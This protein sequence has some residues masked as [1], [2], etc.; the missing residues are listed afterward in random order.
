MVG[1][2]GMTIPWTCGAGRLLVYL[3][4][5]W[6]SPPLTLVNEMKL[7]PGL[8]CLVA[9]VWIRFISCCLAIPRVSW[10]FFL[11]TLD[12]R[13]LKYN[14]TEAGQGR[15]AV[16]RHFL[17]SHT[18]LLITMMPDK[19]IDS[20]AMKW[21]QMWDWGFICCSALMFPLVLHLEPWGTRSY[22]GTKYGRESLF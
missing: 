17:S 4:C 18:A 12:T 3:I 7:L 19:C 11:S 6:Q 16:P 5:C 1:M 8:Q 15:T 2:M 14:E 21:L 20:R 22:S 10:L 13:C 9:M